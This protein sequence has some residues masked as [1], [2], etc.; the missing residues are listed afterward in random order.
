MGSTEEQTLRDH[1]LVLVPERRQLTE[2]EL[3]IL[4]MARALAP[5]LMPAFAA[6]ATLH[7]SG[8]I[9]EKWDVHRI[10]LRSP[11]DLRSLPRNEYREV[12]WDHL[13]A[14]AGYVADPG[15][16]C[17]LPNMD[18]VAK[19]WRDASPDGG[20]EVPMPAPLTQ[21]EARKLLTCTD[22]TLVY[23]CSFPIPGVREWAVRNA[24]QLGG[25]R[26]PDG[27]EIGSQTVL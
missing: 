24:G 16:G 20:P 15:Q 12:A 26:G 11:R 4:A 25:H 6:L 19:W 2:I 18:V 3:Q 13:I 10:T 23:L 9:C 21:D 7:R 17:P 27:P 8:A 22:S 1:G 5:E 14:F